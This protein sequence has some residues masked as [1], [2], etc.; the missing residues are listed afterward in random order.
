MP[1]KYA[2]L[3]AAAAMAA[4]FAL[5]GLGGPADASLLP[6]ADFDSEGRT[7]GLGI[8]YGGGLSLDWGLGKGI[9][10]GISA[11]QLMAPLGSRVDIRM[12]Y[13]F[14]DGERKGL[15]IAGIIGLW[16]DTGFT[17]SPFPFMPPLE[18]GF[19]I[20]YPLTPGL[21]A[22]LNLVVPLFAPRRPFD[23]FGGPAPGLEMGYR[24]RPN[25]EGTLG[26]NG[27]GNLVGVRLGF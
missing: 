6:G 7:L 14:I 13:Q 26:L 4:A 16:A 1:H 3:P 12:L 20:A 2:A 15:S 8:G 18:G 19:G 21:T 24:F 5:W 10:A 9:L 25:L 17:G 11:A 23:A 27:Q 22:R